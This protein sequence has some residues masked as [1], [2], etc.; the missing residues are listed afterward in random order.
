MSQDAGFQ[1]MVVEPGG[2]VA[3]STMKQIKSLVWVWQSDKD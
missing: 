3:S 2:D 1:T